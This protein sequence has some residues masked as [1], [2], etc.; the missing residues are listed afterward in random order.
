MTAGPFRQLEKRL[1][2]CRLDLL[3]RQLMRSLLGLGCE[4]LPTLTE[5]ISRAWPE[6]AASKTNLELIWEAGWQR[7]D[8]MKKILRATEL[9][10][11]EFLM[12]SRFDPFYRELHAKFPS[13][14]YEEI[15]RFAY[16]FKGNKGHAQKITGH[17][18]FAL[19]PLQ[20]RITDTL[21]GFGEEQF[22]GGMFDLVRKLNPQLTEFREVKKEWCRI[23]A[24]PPH[25]YRKIER[26]WELSED[27][28][29][30]LIFDDL[31]YRKLTMKFPL[32]NQETLEAIKRLLIRKKASYKTKYESHRVAGKEVFQNITPELWNLLDSDEQKILGVY[33]GLD[34][35]GDTTRG[36]KA[37]CELLAI[38][39]MKLRN[40]L[41]HAKLRLIR[42]DA[43][44]SLRIP[45]KVV[46]ER[47]DRGRGKRK[48]KEIFRNVARSPMWGSL[49]ADQRK[50]IETY[51]GLDLPE[52]KTRVVK[53]TCEMLGLE[54]PYKLFVTLGRAKLRLAQ[55]DPSLSISSVPQWILNIITRTPRNRLYKKEPNERMPPLMPLITM[56]KAAIAQFPELDDGHVLEMARAMA[57]GD[58]QAQDNLFLSALRYVVPVAIRWDFELVTRLV[59]FDIMDLIQEG[60][61]GLWVFIGLF[62][63]TTSSKFKEFVAHA[64]EAGI[65]TALRYAGMSVEINEEFTK[66]IRNISRSWSAFRKEYGRDPEKDELAAYLGMAIA[67]LE[68]HLNAMRISVTSSFSLDQPISGEDGE[69]KQTFHEVIPD[70]S[71][72]I[73][74]K[75]IESVAEELRDH[76]VSEATEK[77]IQKQLSPIEQLVLSL[78]YGFNDQQELT[79][80]EAGQKL[81]ISETEVSEIERRMLDKLRSDP[82][83]LEKIK[84]FSFWCEI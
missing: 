42:E 70:L 76:W 72:T 18:H 33:Y 10:E 25:I 77:A 74:D 67:E 16:R 29:R 53:E 32:R 15:A 52:G 62:N 63:G 8:A 26:A 27:E 49:D 34:L 71:V 79:P 68:R 82:E 48:D 69:G 7:R 11:A 5:S 64:A 58:E 9:Q 45:P 54:T 17:S 81:G 20:V 1:I 21:L 19:T 50:A 66:A 73:P 6:R 83:V 55:E 41:T 80:K 38:Y 46:R 4:L 13:R 39:P 22:Q 75:L 65:K 23:K 51:Y 36:E 47:G 35:P 30:D 44:L 24:L 57:N 31:W 61:F 28:Y 3:K 59:A 56:Y 14:S 60:N 84:R 12:L 78:R 37:S 40:T 2:Y 43:S